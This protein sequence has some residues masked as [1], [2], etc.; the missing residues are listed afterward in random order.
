MAIVDSTPPE[1]PAELQEGADDTRAFAGAL[2]DETLAI[3]ESTLAYL[4]A[5]MPELREDEQ[6]QRY[7]LGTLIS[8]FELG[9]TMVAFDVDV[10][11]TR[12]PATAIA[13][14]RHLARIGADTDDL[15]R[16]YRL[17]H[18]HFWQ[19]AM[20]APQLQA[21]DSDRHARVIQRLASFSHRF[22]DVMSTQVTAEHLAEQ[23]RHQPGPRSSRD[24]LLAVIAAG[25]D[26]GPAAAQSLGVAPDQPVICVLQAGTPTASSPDDVAACLTALS[27]DAAPLLLVTDAP[28]RQ[29]IGWVRGRA[30]ETART[31]AHRV[32][33]HAATTGIRVALGDVGHGVG[34]LRTSYEQ[35]VRAQRIAQLAG[36]FA[37]DVTSYPDIALVD[38]LTRD[39]PAARTFARAELGEL[40]SPDERDA[41][42]RHTLLTLFAVQFSHASA[43]AALAIHRNTLRQRLERAAERRGAEITARTAELHA[44][45]LLAELVPDAV[46]TDA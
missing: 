13:H 45:L 44:A 43:A 24:E 22:L 29:L 25:G 32:T 21:F 27:R 16:Y 34:A 38:L 1:T 41:L 39:V 11:L 2:L 8:V 31:L 37:G 40:A 3:A 28:E 12:A 18:A 35:A 26:V 33:E 46:L 42:L 9:L 15:M 14:A 36:P 4:M 10:E 17:S 23:R 5:E 19:L 6:T 20:S 7:T 30:R